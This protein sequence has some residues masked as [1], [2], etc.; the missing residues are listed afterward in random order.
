M[1]VKRFLIGSR[2]IFGGY[3]DFDHI[4][5]DT[6]ILI[7]D[8]DPDFD[9]EASTKNTEDGMHYVMWKELSKEELLKFHSV[10][11]KG[12]FIQKFLVPEYIEYIGL[13]IE[14][15]KQL[16]RLCNYLDDEHSYEKIVYNAYIENNGFYLTDEQKEAAYQE[17]KRKR[18]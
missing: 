17:Y 11:Y 4:T 3:K 14:D 12:T 16:G 13:T 1:E 10:C 8:D 5:T 15:L 7:I 9:I 2:A 6:D 18:V